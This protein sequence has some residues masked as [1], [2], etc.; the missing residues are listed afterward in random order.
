MNHDPSSLK[1]AR[2]FLESTSSD[3]VMAKK[4]G[5]GLVKDLEIRLSMDFRVSLVNE[6]IWEGI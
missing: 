2:L 5:F 1:F 6:R 3:L 4:E